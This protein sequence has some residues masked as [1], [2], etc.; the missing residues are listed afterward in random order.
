MKLKI[1]LDNLDEAIQKLEEFAQ[2]LQDFPFSVASESVANIKYPMVTMDSGNGVSHIIAT[3]RGIA[4]QEYGAGFEAE[5]G[6]IGDLDTY[7]GV[8]SE[9]PKG[10]G[11]F[12]TWS[13]TPSEYPYNVTP[14]DYM[15][16]EVQRLIKETPGKARRYFSDN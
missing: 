13:G 15:Q 14:K 3:G 10:K 16:N 7:P 1:T 8:W 2:E 4:F 6:K 11:T 5:T 12:A 9:S